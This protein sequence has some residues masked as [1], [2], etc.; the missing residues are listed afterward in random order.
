MLTASD[1][2]RQLADP[3]F[4][5]RPDHRLQGHGHL[6]PCRSAD[7]THGRYRWKDVF[8]PGGRQRQHRNDLS[9]VSKAVLW[10]SAQN[11]DLSR[12]V[13]YSASEINISCGESMRIPFPRAVII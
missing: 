5:C 7:A 6:V 9:G 8:D 10:Y 1:R 13:I 2:A 12:V 3:G 11:A 4:F